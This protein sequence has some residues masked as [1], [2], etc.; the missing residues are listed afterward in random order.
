MLDGLALPSFLDFCG[1]MQEI[2][3]EC[4]VEQS[5]QSEAVEYN[6]NGGGGCSSKFSSSSSSSSGSSSSSSGSGSGS[7]SGRSSGS[8]HGAAGCG[9]GDKFSVS[10]CSVDGQQCF[11]GECHFV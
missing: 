8:S 4:L 10:I 2:Y 1:D 7:S 9:E 5:G 11:F 3:D 6:S